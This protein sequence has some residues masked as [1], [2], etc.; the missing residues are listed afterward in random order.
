MAQTKSK[1]LF[2]GGT[3]YIGKFIVEASAKAGH[4]TF[5]LVRSP[6]SPIR[7][8]PKSSKASRHPASISSW[9]IFTTTRAL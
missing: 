4:P 5:A 7:P 2:I 8:S 3:G 1:I 9:V 6:P